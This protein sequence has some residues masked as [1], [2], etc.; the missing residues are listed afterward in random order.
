MK[1]NFEQLKVYADIAHKHP[2]KTDVR[3]QL[4]EALYQCGHGIAHHALALKI[5]NTHGECEIDEQEYAI[6]MAFVEQN[7]TPMLIDAF[8]NIASDGNS[9]E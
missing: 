5:Y 7:S 6:I 8:K 2:L 9:Q 3:E 1:I 4:A